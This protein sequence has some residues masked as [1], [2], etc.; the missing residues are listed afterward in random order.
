[1]TATL[2]HDVAD[3]QHTI[4]ELQRRL[5]QVVAER[6]EALARETAT[7]EVLQVINS[8]PGDLAPVFD[9]ILEK[10]HRLC[11][12][13]HGVLVSYDGDSLRAVAMH[14]I[15]QPLAEL[16]R[17]PFRPLPNSPHARMIRDHS[18][19]HIFDV[20]SETLWQRDDPRRIGTVAQGLR[21]MLFVPLCKED[22][23]LGYFT[24]NRLEARPFSEKEIALLQ[25]FAVEAVI[26]IEN[27]HLLTEMREAL[28]QQTATAE[29]LRVI[30]S[31]P[32][33]LAP[34][35]DAILEKA[36]SLCGA[37]FGGL[38]TYDGEAPHLVAERNLPPAWV[39][40]LRGGQFRPRPDHPVSRLKQGEPLIHID[41]MAELART[42][43]D[44][45]VRAAIELGGIR[46]LLLVP[47]RKHD[48]FLG[49]ITAYRQEVRP[50][51]AKQIALLQ[52]FAAQAVI[53]MENARLLGE[54]REALEQQTA[55]SEVLQVINASPGDLQPVFQA[56]L[57]K[58]MHL[59]GAVFGELRTYDGDR[60]QLV[61]TRGTPTAYAEYFARQDTGRYGPG[62]GPARLLDG[63]SVVH[64]PDLIATEPYHRGDPDRRA[65]VDLGGARA[66]VLVPLLADKRV[67][68][69]ILIYRRKP[70]PFSDQ[71]IALLQSF[72]SQAVIAIKNTRL[73]DEIRQ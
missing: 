53:A 26:A 65:L 41:D 27:A 31:S 48:A 73:L 67:C 63:E 16:L 61:A 40:F 8:S 29:V 43:D 59:C 34:V 15:D 12:V 11:G 6:D 19:I 5:D 51:T 18:M 55:T 46:T 60:F 13:T 62:T 2:D 36:H 47:L 57:D 49:Y 72:A 24:A 39:D 45:M 50:F 33:D 68:G 52:N 37:V 54:T 17:K 44:P 21:T 35:F 70:G 42:R 3:P 10:A 4:A 38:L 7:A 66:Y 30:N 28:E 71:Q 23:L 56:M 32:G 64:I 1:M 20:R 9:A 22:K 25:N 69:Y 14:G 58:A